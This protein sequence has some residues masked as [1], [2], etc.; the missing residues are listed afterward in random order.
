[1]KREISELFGEPYADLAVLL[2][3]ARGWAKGH[4]AH[5]PGTA[6]S[7]SRGTVNGEPDPIER[8][9]RAGRAAEVRDLIATAQRA[10]APVAG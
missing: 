1:M 9:L 5:L 10:R 8:L 7:S 6:R 3:D 2:N 4:A